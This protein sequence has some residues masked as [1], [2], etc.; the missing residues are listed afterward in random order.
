MDLDISDERGSAI[1]YDHRGGRSFL[2]E[3]LNIYEGYLDIKDGKW[4]REFAEVVKEHRGQTIWVTIDWLSI[5]AWASS[6]E[7]N[8]N[9][10]Y[11]RHF[12]CEGGE[13]PISRLRRAP[14]EEDL[15]IQVDD[16]PSWFTEALQTDIGIRE[17]KIV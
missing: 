13:S 16:G 6:H 11:I 17:V 2:A 4:W 5:V 3:F 9:L 12:Y 15:Q 7:L 1:S 14:T 8:N 10:A